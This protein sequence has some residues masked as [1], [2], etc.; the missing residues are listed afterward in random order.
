ML[1]L[2]RALEERCQTYAVELQHTRERCGELEHSSE[3]LGGMVEDL[4]HQLSGV[5]EER[6]GTRET[7]AQVLA[8]N[9]A[10][11]P[12]VSHLAAGTRVACLYGASHGGGEGR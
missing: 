12:V 8:T 6:D 1:F 2:Q 7:L 10:M 3:E 4:R 11:A 5:K 9:L